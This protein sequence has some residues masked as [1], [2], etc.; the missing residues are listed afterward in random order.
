MAC[1]EQIKGLGFR[2]YEK[3]ILLLKE[4]LQQA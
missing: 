1:M 4:H 3:A 2:G